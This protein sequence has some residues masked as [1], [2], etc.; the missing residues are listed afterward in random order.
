[1]KK[2]FALI[3]VTLI[4]LSAFTQAPQ[5]MSYQCVIRNA[6]GVLVTN[7]S[8]GIRISVLQGTTSGTV[9]YQEICNPNPQTNTNGL[10][11][12]EIGG[13][14]AIS[15]TF[16]AIDWASGPYFL[17]TETDPTGGTNYTIVGTSQ[18]LSVPYALYAKTA[19][20]ADYYTLTNLPSLSITNWNTTYSWGNHAG[21]YK[22]IS[23]VPTWSEITNKP[24]GNNKGDIQ[25][26]N[27][28]N[29]AIVPVGSPGQYLQLSPLKVPEWSG[30]S[31]PVL[32]TTSASLITENTAN[33]GGNILSDGGVSVSSKGVCYSASSNPTI[34]SSIVTNG[35]ATNTYMCTLPDLTSNSLYYVRS[36]ATNSLGTA[37]GN[38]ISFTTLS[39]GGTPTVTDI[40]G[41][42]Y[43]TITIGSQTWMLENLRTKKY[44][45]G[46][47][48]LSTSSNISA[49]LNAKYQWIHHSNIDSIQS[50]GRLYTWNTITDN[51]G[52][53]PTGFHIPSN[54][55]FNALDDYLTI[56]DYGYEGSGNDIAKAISVN[57]GWLASYYP[58]TPGNDQTS[59]NIT[60][61]S[62]LPAGD[63]S[64]QDYGLSYDGWKQQACFWTC[65]PAGDQL[66]V[67]ALM[68]RIYFERSVIETSDYPKIWGFSVRCIKD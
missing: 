33:V 15:G 16:T 39:T 20:T 51:R 46:D 68:K 30:A 66:N 56:N 21:L 32:T 44:R 14:L 22:P 6:S 38:E 67:R 12:I 63:I 1:M 23:Y 7:Q 2:L 8:V 65:T 10:L 61:F 29:W 3:M 64:V 4:T 19:G 45:N 9:V 52:V 60:G 24:T 49:E 53:C 34:Y 50:Y 62:V 42:I 47:I 59:N 41:N 48:I 35:T 57:S 17:E 55:E 31:Y 27:G 13:G 18:F 25:Y 28:T 43:R 5:K 40:E 36:F 11:S 58:G 54:G 37:Y 26:W